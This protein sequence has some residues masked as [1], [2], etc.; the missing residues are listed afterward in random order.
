MVGIIVTGHGNFATGVLSAAKLIA[1][2]PEKLIGIDFTENDTVETLEEKI[3]KGIEELD[4]EEI[5][6]LA[7]LAGGSPFK[8]SATIGVS[9]DKNIKVLSG[10]NLGMIIET[11]LLRDGKNLEEVVA[12]AKESGI[13]SIQEFEMKVKKEIEDCEDGI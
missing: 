7:D 6:V 3:K 12:F 10:T 2:T 1:G 4:T 5:L 13:T 11:A 9:S 8:V